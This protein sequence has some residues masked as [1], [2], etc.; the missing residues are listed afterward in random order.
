[1]QTTR[2]QFT[3]MAGLAA[4]GLFLPRLALSA[5]DKEFRVAQPWEFN[6]LNPRNSGYVFERA[7]VIEHLA[8]TEPDGR[9]VPSI[10]ESWGANA[11]ATEWRFVIRKGVK[12]HDG[13]DATPKAIR[14]GFEKLLPNM[15]NL[16]QAGLNAVSNDE[17]GVVFHLD[18]PFGPFPAYLIHFASPV[19]APGSFDAEGNVTKLIGTGPFRLVEARFPREAVLVANDDYWGQKPSIR[20]II[21]NTYD[22]GETR[23]NVAIAGDAELVAGVPPTAIDRVIAGGNMRIERTLAPWTHMVLIN[24]AKP[25]FSELA[26]RRALSLAMDR[27]GIATSIMRNP[28][29]TATQYFP[30]V[31]P[32]W[33]TP[34]LEPFKRDVEAANS[35][36]DE[37]GWV[38]GSDG[39]RVKSGVRFAGSLRTFA[40]RPEF[41]VIATALQSQFAEIGFELTISI[42]EW[43][44]IVEGQR[45]GTLDLAL[46]SQNIAAQID[47]IGTVNLDFANDEPSGS[48]TGATNW[49]ND[50]FRANVAAYLGETDED[51]KSALRR[52]IAT[53]IHEE[54]PVLPVCW[55]EQ[56]AGYSTEIEGAVADPLEKRYLIERMAWKA[57]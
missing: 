33:H 11:E 3:F 56:I 17:D 28:A 36:L 39:I 13:T 42:G 22:N 40:N 48:A 51:K 45:D 47:P 4:G 5:N 7:G 30:S 19:L 20:K 25:Q 55:Y 37:A 43:Q 44:A 1:M 50:D 32:G 8:I 29:L 27:A 52:A 16:K 18:R 41:P 15:T 23:G 10:A 24:V 12:F 49:R 9:I 34:G 54:L 2:R 6:S 31:L 35:L 46:S 21:L 38:R 26:T 57:S 14:E 53:T